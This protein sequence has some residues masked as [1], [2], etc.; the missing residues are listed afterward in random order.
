MWKKILALYGQINPRNRAYSPLIPLC[1]SVACVWSAYRTF[2]QPERYASTGRI[3][4]SGRMNLADSNTYMEELNNFIGTQIEIIR[5]EAL[6][7]RARQSLLST[8]PALAGSVSIEASWLRGTAIFLVNATGSEPRYTEAY[9]NALLQQYIESR[10]D[11]RIETSLDAMQK[12]REEILRIERNLT[13]QETELY[14]F[15]EKHNMIYWGRQ[16]TDAGQY[17]SELML[18]EAD[19]ELR[20]RMAENLR[21]DPASGTADR[22]AAAGDPKAKGGPP[23]DA[24]IPVLRRQLFERLLDREQLLAIYKPAHPKISA[25]NLEINK[26]QRLL[27]QLLSEEEALGQA[28]LASMRS[29][30]AGVRESIKDW[31]TKALDS[32]RTEA[33]HERLQTSLNRT[34]DLYSRLI[35][36]LQSV[37]VGKEVSVD[38]VQILQRATPAF[39]VARPLSENLRIASGLGLLAGIGLVLMLGRFDPRA[40]SAAEIATRVDAEPLAEIPVLRGLNEKVAGAGN[41]ATP[42]PLTESVRTI[43][44]SLDF[45]T[46]TRAPAQL[47]FCVSTCPGEGKSTL[48]LHLALHAAQSGI[49]TLLIDG[50]LRRGHLAESL[51]LPADREGLAEILDRPQDDWRRVVHTLKEPRLDFIARGR[52][53]PYTVDQLG[54]WLQ[55]ETIKTLRSSYSLIVIDAAPLAPI[56]D[57]M[58]F[59]RV[60]DRVL[61]VTRVKTTP[62]GPAERVARLIR[63]QRPKGFDLIINSCPSNLLED[64]YYGGYNYSETK[65]L[66]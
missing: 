32:T 38:P 23:R 11:R 31:E 41:A 44:S 17:L 26:Q 24:S 47:I 65:K 55:S 29:E 3:L 35:N 51:S 58:R 66:S 52:P 62:L 39:G 7:T 9:L 34:R 2:Q 4:V 27:D 21:T 40:F 16:S 15:K 14:A 59:L 12:L 54:L 5:S 57:S 6:A 53:N 30:L 13:E 48:A 50:D 20:L 49:R 64:G 22:R 18:R 43:L 19:L 46:D 36:S 33:E 8:Q 61:F 45:I 63:S 25:L 56:S 10:S 28:G 1:I 37:S 42:P 60:V